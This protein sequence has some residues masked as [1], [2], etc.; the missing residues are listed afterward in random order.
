MF[1]CNFTIRGVQYN[2]SENRNLA[3]AFALRLFQG[4][5]Y[6][7]ENAEDLT[8]LDIFNG[9]TLEN[10]FSNCLV[11]LRTGYNNCLWVDHQRNLWL[12]LTNCH[13]FV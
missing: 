11:T 12:P 7:V 13:P 2:S 10:S 6:K 1:P 4:Q 3:D 9:G 5:L 8:I